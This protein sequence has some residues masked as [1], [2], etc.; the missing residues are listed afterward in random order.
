MV[1]V[2]RTFRSASTLRVGG[3]N[4]IGSRLSSQVGPVTFDLELA[5]RLGKV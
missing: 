5:I 3:Y 2:K 4:Q 1:V